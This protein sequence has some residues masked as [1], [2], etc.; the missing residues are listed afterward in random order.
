MFELPAVPSSLQFA[1]CSFHLNMF[2]SFPAASLANCVAEKP[3]ANY[4]HGSGSSGLGMHE[5]ILCAPATP[6][7]SIPIAGTDVPQDRTSHKATPGL[8]YAE[9]AKLLLKWQYWHA[10]DEDRTRRGRSQGTRL[11]LAREGDVVK[12]NGNLEVDGYSSPVK[13]SWR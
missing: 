6:V 11:K 12:R 9:L 2:H 3:W 8:D 10:A 7:P 1:V 5:D 4:L 13:R